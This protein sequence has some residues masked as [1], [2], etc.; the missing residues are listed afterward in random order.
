MKLTIDT[1]TDTLENLQNVLSLLIKS[2]EKKGGKIIIQ[3]PKQEE[4]KKLNME[5][6]YVRR[7]IEQEKLME[8]INMSSILQSDYGIQKRRQ[9]SL[10]KNL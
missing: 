10:R 1:E 4:Q 8:T 7:A 9:E 3:Q 6:A 2:I 5:N